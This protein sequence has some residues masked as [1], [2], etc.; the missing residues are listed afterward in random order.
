MAP[1][2]EEPTLVEGTPES[3]PSDVVIKE[4]QTE[5][6][7]DAESE[8]DSKEETPEGEVVTEDQVTTKNAFDFSTMCC[9]GLPTVFS[10]DDEPNEEQ[11]QAEKATK[12]QAVFRAKQARATTEQ[13]KAERE[14][15][16]E[17]A[18]KEAAAPSKKPTFMEKVKA[19]F[20]GCKK[21][22]AA[23]VQ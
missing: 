7:T 3:L 20:G 10:K 6:K 5:E 8:E 17:K 22:D 1:Q 14:A 23:V 2:A 16:K 13:L 21:A 9:G 11:V 15:A 4:E 19:L 12:I 18:L